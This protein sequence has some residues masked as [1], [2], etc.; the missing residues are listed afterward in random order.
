V[1]FDAP[2]CKPGSTGGNTLDRTIAELGAM[3]ADYYVRQ[4]IATHSDAHADT[5][6]YERKSAARLRR[7]FCCECPQAVLAGGQDGGRV[8]Y[9]LPPARR[10]SAC[11][12]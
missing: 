11:A 8:A 3:G 9:F 7:S 2:T 4:W 5:R 10:S 12:G 1:K 6:E